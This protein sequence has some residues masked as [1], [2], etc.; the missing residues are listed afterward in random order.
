MILQRIEK[1]H[2]INDDFTKMNT[3]F[4]EEDSSKGTTDR[5]LRL[6]VGIEGAEDLIADFE[7]VFKSWEA[8]SV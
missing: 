5:L 1:N 7:N 6:S 8:L 4:P 3:C 2:H